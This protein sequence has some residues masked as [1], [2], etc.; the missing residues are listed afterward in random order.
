[1]HTRSGMNVTC[2]MT[3]RD[4]SEV[5]SRDGHRLLQLQLACDVGPIRLRRLLDH[6]GSADAAL[7]ASLAELERVEDIGPKTA[8]A[9]RDARGSE[10]VEREIA[11]A[12]ACG[13]RIVSIA[14]PDYPQQLVH[15]PDAPSCLYV[16]GS[17]EP[18]DAVAVAIVG[19]RRCS[20]YGRE[21]ASRFGELL[22]AAGFTVVSGLARGIDGCAHEGAL[23]GGGRTIAV[24][25][26]GLATVYPPEH[27]ALAERITKNG[28]LISEIPI[29]AA[30]DAKNFPGRNRVIAG[31]ALGVIVIEAGQRSGALIT[32]RHALDYNRELFALPGRVDSPG[33]T[34]GVNG[35]IRD[36]NAKLITGLDD[37]LD[38]LQEVGDIMRPEAAA[39]DAA[40]ASARL[41]TEAKP[42]LPMHEQA[43]VDAVRGGSEV[44]DA[45][46]GAAGLE[47][48]RAMT[49]LTS[50]EIKGVLRRL[51]GDRFAL[52]GK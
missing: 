27:E 38:E 1:M 6:F 47:L 40:N 48:P 13:V 34:A 3:T 49:A 52:R 51:P 20:H 29:D 39:P 2:D 37:I 19:T 25:G 17:L 21:Q 33:L 32:A 50:L 7:E 22:G 41:S 46:A 43:V 14:D 4:V 26:N 45:I 30:P 31:L 11:R 42:R 9:I 28:A 44:A 10:A 36:G 16:K 15:T 35:L 23:R 5:V 12:G 24:L 8:R 18:Q